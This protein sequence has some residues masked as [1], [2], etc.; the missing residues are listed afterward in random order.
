MNI[1]VHLYGRIYM[2]TY[3]YTCVYLKVKIYVCKYMYQDRYLK[4]MYL[5]YSKEHDVHTPFF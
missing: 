3:M 4:V 2:Y 1:C 5:Q